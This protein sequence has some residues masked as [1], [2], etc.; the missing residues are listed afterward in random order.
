MRSGGGKAKGGAFEREIAKRLSLWITNGK[1]QDVFWRSA[2]SGGR[3]TVARGKVRQAGDICAVAEEGNVFSEQWFIECKHVKKLGLDSFLISNRGPLAEFWKKA[4][5]EARKYGR[6][7]LLIC[8]QNGWPPIVITRPDHLSHICQP[9]V[10]T[11]HAL[12]RVCVYLFDDWMKEPSK[13]I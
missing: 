7:P 9:I 1:S 10:T 3:A 11:H 4:C 5:I 13:C 8:K 12:P 2:M 6:D